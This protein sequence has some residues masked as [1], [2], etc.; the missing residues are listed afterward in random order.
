[1]VT[2]NF[3]TLPKGGKKKLDC[4]EMFYSVMGIRV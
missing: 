2:L 1:M 4:V 3:D